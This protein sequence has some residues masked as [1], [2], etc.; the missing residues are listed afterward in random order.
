[1]FENA[2]DQASGLRELFELPAG[3]AVVPMIAARSS[4]GFRSLVT[5]IAAGYARLG[6]RVIVIDAGT[7]GT[8]AALGL[9]TPNDLAQLLSGEC[10]FDDVV[11]QAPDGLFVLKA[12]KGIPEFVQMS[13]DPSDLFLAF[14]RLEKP[15][16][17]AI[18]AGHVSEVAAMTREDDDLVLVT[19][20]DSG[21][22]TATYAEIKRAHAEHGHRAFRVLINRVDDQHE[23]TVAFKRLAATARRFLGVGIEYGG[24]VFRD[25]VFTS[26]DRSQCS[27]FGVN[28]KSSAAA[29]MSQLVKSM[30]AWRLG[31]YVLNEN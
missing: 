8:G 4:M 31:R 10:E 5:N 11:V 17:V 16:D 1:M 18:L 28:T 26:A 30:Q 21:A 20:A 6:Q 14:R 7:A 3:L 9:R 12:H 23:A 24:A 2:V 25:A 22:L 27:I 13:G 15:F 19:N 29:Q